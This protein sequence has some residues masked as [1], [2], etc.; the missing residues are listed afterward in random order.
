MPTT[1]RSSTLDDALA[2]VVRAA[3]LALVL[4]GT[5]LASSVSVLGLTTAL[6][7]ADETHDASGPDD[8]A[9]VGGD[10]RF[11]TDRRS[12]VVLP[13]PTEEDAFT[14]AVFGDRTGGPR[15]G[16]AVLEQAVADVNL[17]GPDLVMTVGDL[18]EGYN[19][20]DPWLEEMREFR[21]IMGRLRMPWFPVAG[22]HDIYWRGA[23]RPAEEHE[24]DYEQHFGPLWY[25]FEHKG[26]WFVVLYTDEGDPDTGRRS[27]SDHAS[28]RMSEAQLAW[29]DA[30]LE[31]TADARH[32]FVFLHHPRWIAER[33][34]ND[35][36]RVHARLARAGNV[37]AVFAGHIHRMR[38]DGVRD[39]IEYFTLAAVGGHLEREIPRGGFL[40]EYHLVT[41]RDAGLEVAAFPVGT[42]IDVRALTGEVMEDVRRVDDWLPGR[43]VERPK[44]RGSAVTGALVHEFENPTDRRLSLT[45][46]LV[47]SDQWFVSADHQH[48]VLGPRETT[49]V[50]FAL[51]HE[52]RS[53]LR[54]LPTVQIEARIET[55]DAVFPL[56]V[57]TFPVPVELLELAPAARGTSERV[58]D[59][60]GRDGQVRIPSD[61]IELPDGPFTL[62]CWMKADAFRARQG[63]VAKTEGS[64][65]GLFVSGGRPTFSVH[66]DGDY[67]TAEASGPPLAVGTW[68]HVAG[69]FDGAEVRILVDGVVRGRAAG[70]GARRTNSLPLVVG[71]DVDGRGRGTS[72]FAGRIDEVRLSRGARYADGR[73]PPLRRL[74]NDPATVLLLHF[75]GES[76]W[77][78][79]GSG[80]SAHGLL[81][82]G[83]RR[84]LESRAR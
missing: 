38:Y 25:A 10:E 51:Q 27:I 34:G 77:A 22:N 40:H 72:F 21:G 52:A 57:R 29:L 48:T 37:R 76:P 14:F 17:I 62:E 11:V 19:E 23:G 74:A 6:T 39:G 44:A 12:P 63:L 61:R 1:H 31:R 33:Y 3:A 41:V 83:A 9:A 80:S 49:R 24:S 59:L 26:C 28:Q 16:I 5:S 47:A 2:N 79:D 50:A 15:E 81:E 4:A 65:Y 13:L 54:S 53:P 46:S 56:P 67:V 35:W 8:E 43:V 66:L 45:T 18:V 58:L 71:A 55:E 84:T 64:E 70:S 36:E 30:T 82:G 73:T 7:V 75:D 68:H 78:F 42:A 60:D 20:R 69:V 32:V